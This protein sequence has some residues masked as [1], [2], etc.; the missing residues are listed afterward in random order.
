ML[1]IHKLRCFLMI[2]DVIKVVLK[3]LL[4]GLRV[5]YQGVRENI[6]NTR[7][8]ERK[9]LLLFSM[10]FWMSSPL[11][12]DD[13][14]VLILEENKSSAVSINKNTCMRKENLAKGSSLTVKANGRLWLKSSPSATSGFAF[15]IICQNISARPV[16]THIDGFLPPWLRVSGSEQCTPWGVNNNLSCSNKASPGRKSFFCS[17][18]RED[19]SKV[20]FA[21]TSQEKSVKVRGNWKAR[22]VEPYAKF[23]KHVSSD[24]ALCKQ[25]NNITSNI[26]MTWKV[27]GSENEK[28]VDIVSPLGLDEHFVDCALAVLSSYDFDTHE[29]GKSFK[30]KF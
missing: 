5:F 11:K 13:C 2:V 3:F 15:Q 30:D 18:A 4:N 19:K 8:L 29:L 12:A 20:A 25:V 6:M 22:S 23:Q 28:Y 7:L 24:M 14:G 10:S 9:L 1:N 27:K 16:T 26:Q 21:G 17:L